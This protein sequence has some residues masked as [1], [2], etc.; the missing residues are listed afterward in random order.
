MIDLS[1]I[2]DGT[3]ATTGTGVPT[4]AALTVTRVSTNV[5]DFLAQRDVGVGNAYELDVHCTVTTAFTAAGAAT[6][7][8]SY[9]TSPDNI[10][11]VDT[12]FTPVY[13]VAD[14]VVGAAIMRYR[15]P[16]MQLN[17]KGP[18][19]R[20]HRLSYVVATGPMTAGALFAY[21]TGGADRGNLPIYGPN[22][23]VGA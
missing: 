3:V 20:Y 2:F 16:L 17:D 15:V 14:L 8:I 22:Y 6:L 23:S 13:A 1:L 19:N 21:I 9:Q 4:G 12:L 10:T 5:L 18:P 11:F 7:Q